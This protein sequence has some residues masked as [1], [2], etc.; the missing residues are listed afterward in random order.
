MSSTFQRDAATRKRD[1]A[2]TSISSEDATCDARGV[3]ILFAGIQSSIVICK[4]H[5]TD[6]R[7]FYWLFLPSW[8]TIPR[9]HLNAFSR[10]RAIANAVGND[11]C[12][13]LAQPIRQYVSSAFFS[14]VIFRYETR[15]CVFFF[16]SEFP[17]DIK[18]EILKH[19]VPHQ[20]YHFDIYSTNLRTRTEFKQRLTVYF[21]LFL[22]MFFF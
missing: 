4:R 17:S 16:P 8:L 18:Y 3:P 22:D 1:S 2:I 10:S 6:T 19:D 9:W 5:Y 14:I 21:Y 15:L 13:Q 12:I 7:S 11:N 20:S